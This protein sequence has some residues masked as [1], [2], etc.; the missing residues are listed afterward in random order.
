[1]KKFES[2]HKFVD[3]DWLQIWL[4]PSWKVII[5]IEIYRGLSIR[6]GRVFVHLFGRRWDT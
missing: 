3:K 6:V 1:M 5:F 4:N 2:G